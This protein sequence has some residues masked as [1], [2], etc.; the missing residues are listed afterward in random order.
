MAEAEQTSLVAIL[1]VFGRVQDFFRG[2]GGGCKRN[3]SGYERVTKKNF[4]KRVKIIYVLFLS[5]FYN[6]VKHFFLGGGQTS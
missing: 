2:G 6:L 1:C 3:F 4:K 5:R